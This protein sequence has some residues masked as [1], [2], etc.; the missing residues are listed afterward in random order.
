MFG[1]VLGQS[2]FVLGED[3]IEQYF[4]RGIGEESFM[5]VGNGG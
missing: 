5:G 3:E 4:T 2:G 1:G